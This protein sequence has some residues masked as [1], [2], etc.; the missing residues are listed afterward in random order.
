MSVWRLEWL[1]VW[2][3]R[4]L[5]VLLGTFVILGLGS[6]MLT[7]YLPDIVK[8]ATSDGVQII[9]PEQTA[10]DGIQSFAS[11]LNQLGTLIVV[12][13]AAGTLCIDANPILAAFYRT[14]QRG[15]RLL[16]P[17]Y[18]TLTAAVVAT[19]ALGT[20]GAWYETAI[21]LGPLRATDVLGGFLLQALWFGF[22]TSVVAAAASVVRGVPG[23]I[24]AAVALLLA[25][26][27]APG[28]GVLASHP[29][30]E[31]RRAPRA[32]TGAALAPRA[33]HHSHDLPAARIGDQP[34]RT[35]R[36]VSTADEQRGTA[37][38]GRPGQAELFDNGRNT[39]MC[40]TAYPFSAVERDAFPRG[41]R[42]SPSR[43]IV[44]DARLAVVPDRGCAHP[45]PPRPRRSS[46]RLSPSVRVPG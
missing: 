30:R 40:G 43:V 16:L 23:A 4:R 46:P 2:R 32:A 39:R 17:R 27:C 18:A 34:L 9:V 10:T 12:V 5:I 41:C 15:R 33:R 31:R 42:V 3:T 26:T 20:L 14:R 8:G 29:A 44:S 6:P 1:R 25:I 7:Y 22:V 45:W 24:G 11:N 37:A 21:L 35:A 19:L 13:V 28:A 38:G 36:T